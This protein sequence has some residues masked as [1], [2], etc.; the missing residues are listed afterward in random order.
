MYEPNCG[1]SNVQM[2]W[3]HDEYMYQVLIHNGSKIPKEGLYMVRF[4]SF[5]PWH[6]GGDYDHLCNGEDREM[7]P[8]IKEFNQFD[9]Y[10]KADT[11]PDVEK[12]KPYYQ[13]LID[14]YCPGK[15]KW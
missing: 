11:L 13:S 12:V 8:W 9:L 5:Y 14:K 10:S 4:H 2:S 15:L 1:L 3:G 7:M 6:S